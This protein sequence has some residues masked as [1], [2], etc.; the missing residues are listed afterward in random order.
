MKINNI[1]K[2]V[3]AFCVLLT[4][5]L[6]HAQTFQYDDL[7]RI[8]QISYDSTIVDLTYDSVGNRKT[9]VINDS[10]IVV[11]VELTYFTAKGKQDG[12]I[13]SSQ[14]DWQTATELNA[15]HYDIEYSADGKSFEKIGEVKA[16]GNSNQ[17]LNYQYLH[18]S[19]QFG[20]NYYRLKQVDYDGQYHYSEIRI[21]V[22]NLDEIT[23]GSISIYPNPASNELNIRAIESW[24]GTLTQ[25][26]IINQLGQVSIPPIKK[27][28][29][30]NWKISTTNLSNGTYWLIITDEFRNM[31]TKEFVVLKR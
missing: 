22:F 30:S 31:E 29:D 19:P 15:S 6:L 1:K 17:L 18:N 7:H 16:A 26:K 27:V 5:Q 21:V 9:I 14:L 12:S 23:N 10:R 28:D 20:V 3:I 13:I 8:I 24:E 25:V 11:P 4:T 2:Y